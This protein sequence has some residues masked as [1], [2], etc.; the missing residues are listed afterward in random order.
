MEVIQDKYYR[1][2]VLDDESSEYEEVPKARKII[3]PGFEAFEF[4]AYNS[5]AKRRSWVICEA[6][7]GTMVYAGWVWEK[8][9]PILALDAAEYLH[10]KLAAHTINIQDIIQ[11]QIIKHGL[12]PRY[13]SDY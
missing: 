7:S 4:F 2:M 1:Y 6:T 9:L 12:S 8:E 3:L 13:S 10:K 5:P 11:S